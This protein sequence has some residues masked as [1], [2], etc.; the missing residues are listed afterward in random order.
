MINTTIFYL[1][2]QHSLINFDT[3]GPDQN[4]KVIIVFN[5]RT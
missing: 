3:N 4:V 1:L 5:V 2:P